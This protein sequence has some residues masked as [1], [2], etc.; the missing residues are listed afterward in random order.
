MFALPLALLLTLPPAP[1]VAS[2]APV[3]AQ[4]IAERHQAFS[5]FK[6]LPLQAT[7]LPATGHPFFAVIAS[8][9]GLVD[10]DG[11]NAQLKDPANGSVIQSHP[12]RDFAQWLASQG[13]GS[14]R[15]DKRLL[16]PKDSSLDGSL[17]AQVGD[18][19]AALSTARK[20][21]E[22]QGRKLLLVG[23]EEGAL[24]ALQ[25][26]SDADALLAIGMPPESMAKSTRSQ[27]QAQLPSE[28]AAA[29]LDYLDQVFDA[30][31]KQQ[32]LPQAGT[33]VHSAMVGL[34]RALMNPETLAF[35]RA[36]LDLDPWVLTGR[37]GVP[38]ALVWGEVDIQT[39]A[40]SKTPDTYRGAFILVPQA[41][42]LLKRE[43]RARLGL[44]AAM[45]VRNYGDGTPL[46][47]LSPIAAWLHKL[48][49]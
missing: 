47:D 30:I 22:A 12:Q 24:M 18:L 26:A 48:A 14:L 21:P 46:A 32:P 11:F 49:E 10:R 25:A 2:P 36:M 43:G 27:L 16:S 13:I 7:I 42:H 41:N 15:F 17:E 3:Q 33:N 5:G 9:S 8:A 37:L 45:A 44:T 4:S 29:N 40:P 39:L 23:F 31:R 6:D 1:E 19:R 20:L 28:H 38:S 35:T 34:G